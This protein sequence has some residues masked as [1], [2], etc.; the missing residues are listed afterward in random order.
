M[1]WPTGT[2]GAK[3]PRWF[4]LRIGGLAKVIG[5]RMMV[6]GRLAMV[7]AGS[8]WVPGRLAMVMD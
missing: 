3:R 2:W 8:R 7:I 1:V 6:P 4:A 5:R